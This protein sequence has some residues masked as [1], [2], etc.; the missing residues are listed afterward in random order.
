M[1]RSDRSEPTVIP[2]IF[3]E[4]ETETAVAEPQ[5]EPTITEAYNA[6]HEGVEATSKKNRKEESGRNTTLAAEEATARSLAETERKAPRRR[7]QTLQEAHDGVIPEEEADLGADNIPEDLQEFDPDDL[8]AAMMRLGLEDADLEDPRWVKALRMAL[9]NQ[10]GEDETEEEE[11]EETEEAK[12][13]EKPAAA[14]PDAKSKLADLTP[15][16]KQ[17][18]QAHIEQVYQR[19]KQ[20]NNGIY[21]EHFCSSLAKAL[22]CPPEEMGRLND[23]VEILEYGAQN[24]LQT[25]LPGLVTEYMQANF[26]PQ[27]GAIL[28]SYAPGL[29]DSFRTATVE[30]TWHDVC[31]MEEFKDAHLP[32]FG[33][34]EFQEAAQKVHAANP[35]LN[36]FD[37]KGPDGKLL[38][39]LEALRVRAVVTARL[40]AGE[41]MSPKVMAERIADAVETGRKSAE[42]S[43]R[44][45]SASRVLRG[46]RTAGE[47]GKSEGGERESLMDAW[48]RGGGGGAL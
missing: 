4:A 39:V 14:N 10:T 47:L 1:L 41:R 17:V 31:D 8:A 35:W 11:T 42:R 5:A 19:A 45:V 32:R 6:E 16:E 40:L 9:E 25:A 29:A 2:F 18:M 21:H 7:E 26:A 12:P 20:V 34:P 38:P 13:E 43:T 44:R 28:E 15:E 3:A 33:T 37:P 23:V 27:F 46:G 48:R 24:L 36:D 30:N 22:E